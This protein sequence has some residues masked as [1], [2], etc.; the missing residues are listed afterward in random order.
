M[1]HQRE[2]REIKE[3]YDDILDPMYHGDHDVDHVIAA[4][5]RQRAVRRAA[6]PVTHVVQEERYIAPATPVVEA[7]PVKSEPE[8]TKPIYTQYD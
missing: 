7:A 1:K 8:I 2:I 4:Q 6:P 5:R 3:A